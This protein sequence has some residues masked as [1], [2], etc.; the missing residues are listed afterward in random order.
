[1]RFQIVLMLVLL[2]STISAFAQGSGLPV[3]TRS[4]DNEPLQIKVGDKLKLRVEAKGDGISYKWVNKEKVI[5]RTSSCEVDTSAW[6]PGQYTVVVVASNKK[7]ARTVRYVF[8]VRAAKEGPKSRTIEPDVIDWDPEAESPTAED[9]YVKAKAG[10][11]YW[12]NDKDRTILEALPIWLDWKGKFRSSLGIVEFG[13]SNVEQHFLLPR[14]EAELKDDE[15][16]HSIHLSRGALRSRNFTKEVAPWKIQAGLWNVVLNGT[17]DIIVRAQGE[18]DKFKVTVIALRGEASV[19]RGDK[20]LAVKTGTM[21]VLEGEAPKEP[22]SLEAKDWF[23]AVKLTTPEYLSPKDWARIKAESSEQ[24]SDL[25]GSKESAKKAL[26]QND[27]FGALEILLP[28]HKELPKDFD[29]TLIVGRAYEGLGLHKRAIVFYDRASK[30]G[31]QHPEPKFRMGVVYS[32]MTKWPQALTNL[33]DAEDLGYPDEQQLYYYLGYAHFHSEGYGAAN[34]AFN[35][36]LWDA[37]DEPKANSARDYLGRLGEERTWVLQGEFSL[38]NDSNVFHTGDAQS[39]AELGENSSLAVEAYGLVEKKFFA[40]K[41]GSLGIGYKAR[42]RHYF[43]KDLSKLDMNDQNIKLGFDLQTADYYPDSWLALSGRAFVTS[44]A[45]ASKRSM[46]GVGFGGDLAIPA[47]FGMPTVTMTQIDHSDPFPGVE[48]DVIDFQ[49]FE[50]IEPTD[51]SNRFTSL[52]FSLRFGYMGPHEFKLG[53]TNE[54]RVFSAAINEGSNYKDSKYA[55]SYRRRLSWKTDLELSAMSGTRSFTKA[56]DDRKDKE[57][58]FSMGL[59]R[60][61]GDWWYMSA[62]HT[63]EKVDSNREGASYD[64]QLTTLAIG[65]EN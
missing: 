45:V 39:V 57:T 20:V 52:D 23:G 28:H 32:L 26:E 59:T 65:L 18:G 37:L 36:S 16:R 17:S 30:L 42:H 61:F 58:A 6:S 46:D 53:L 34:R 1:M 24:P 63:V 64:R 14:G 54:A 62:K 25:N 7:G 10:L 2:G 13:L 19:T 21:V 56:T 38:L 15:G 47:L 5:C 22:I 31:P 11:G 44:L 43:A 29:L 48:D 51:R 35:A 41:N 40:G 4:S 49:T 3:F 55:L 12:Y 50:L 60:R 27:F 8:R 9:A 33:E